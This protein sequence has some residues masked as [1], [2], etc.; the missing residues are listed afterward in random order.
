[1]AGVEV[2]HP[3]AA[4]GGDDLAVNAEAVVPAHAGL[5]EMAVGHSLHGGAR[6]VV[7]VPA[8]VADEL[9]LEAIAIEQQL[10][11]L[12]GVDAKLH[13]VAGA[14]PLRPGVAEQAVGQEA[15][16]DRGAAKGDADTLGAEAGLA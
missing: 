8:D 9:F 1:A 11:R 13:R 16:M 4:G 3:A 2:V 15:E 10:V 5:D 14:A 12:D 7:V 6:A